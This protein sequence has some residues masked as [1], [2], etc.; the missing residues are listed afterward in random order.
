MLDDAAIHGDLAEL[1]DRSVLSADSKDHLSRAAL[2]SEL[3]RVAE[4]GWENA[5][6]ALAQEWAK[7][8][9]NRDIEKAYKWYHIAFAWDDYETAW[10]N[11]NA[12]DDVY[13]GVDGDFRNES[14]VSELVDAISHSR[15][16][17]LDEE[18][19]AWLSLH[20]RQQ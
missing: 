17:E 10:N 2:I 19:T 3:E 15:L 7:P 8:G 6:F 14:V 20:D 1:Y 18:A 9:I 4:A 12:P 5:A 11:Q 16:Q 13:L